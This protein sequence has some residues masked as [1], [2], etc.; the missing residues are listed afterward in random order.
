MW[1]VRVRPEETISF[2]VERSSSRSATAVEVGWVPALGPGQEYLVVDSGVSR[3][4]RPWY[5]VV[6]LLPDG[7]RGDAT[8]TFQAPAPP[9]GAARSRQRR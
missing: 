1:K 5:R 3:D 2:V 4:A 6:E 9:G 8:P 7:R